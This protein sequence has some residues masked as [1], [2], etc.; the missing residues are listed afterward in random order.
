MTRKELLEQMERELRGVNNA[1]RKKKYETEEERREAKRERNRRYRA[2]LGGV[3]PYSQF[4]VYLT[5]EEGDLLE[6]VAKR[7]KIS[8]SELV[9]RM[10]KRFIQ[11]D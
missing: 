9:R 10:I 7:M 3:M 2:K 8:K 4:Q 11:I 5:H 1:G 6:T